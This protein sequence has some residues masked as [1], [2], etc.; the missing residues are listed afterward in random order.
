MKLVIIEGPGKRETLKKYLGEGY[1]VFATK[2]HVRDLPVSE[3]GVDLKSKSPAKYNMVAEIA[4][5]AHNC[6][7]PVKEAYDTTIY[8]AQIVSGMLESTTGYKMVDKA[9]ELAKKIY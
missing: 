2:G 1:E 8:E 4:N 7:I 9:L 5:A 3:F 6:Y